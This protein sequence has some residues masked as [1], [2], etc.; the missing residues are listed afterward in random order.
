MSDG[1]PIRFAARGFTSAT[2]PRALQ[3]WPSGPMPLSR[4]HPESRKLLFFFFFNFSILSIERSKHAMSFLKLAFCSVFVHRQA[5]KRQL[6]F[7][8][9]GVVMAWRL[10]CL[11]S[12]LL[13][14]PSEATHFRGGT[15]SCEPVDNSTASPGGVTSTGAYTVSVSRHVSL[16]LYL[17]FS[18]A[19]ATESE[20]RI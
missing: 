2:R 14:V 3:C 19:G 12:C 10:L 1:Q 13:L 20:R 18:P 8:S 6:N 9:R 4:D 15:I 5:D 11:L 7:H 16:V 17:N